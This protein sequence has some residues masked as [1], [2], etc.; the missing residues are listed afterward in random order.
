MTNAI[1]QKDLESMTINVLAPG[2]SKKTTK[3]RLLNGEPQDL[4]SILIEAN[5]ITE[6]ELENADLTIKETF[7]I[8][9]RYDVSRIIAKVKNGIITISIPVDK[10]KVQT[11]EIE[12]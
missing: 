7:H 4:P 6:P 5:P 2:A 9:K 10:R 3:I 12:D 8:E 1:Q 11:I